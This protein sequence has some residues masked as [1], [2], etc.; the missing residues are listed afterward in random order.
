MTNRLLTDEI[1]YCSDIRSQNDQN[2]RIIGDFTKMV[3]LVPIVEKMHALLATDADWRV[4][5]TEILRNSGL[6]F[7]N[8]FGT[9]IS[10]LERACQWQATAS[11]T[12]RRQSLQCRFFETG[13]QFYL[14]KFLLLLQLAEWKQK[15]LTLS[16]FIKE[17]NSPGNTK[18]GSAR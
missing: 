3:R 14:G 8:R 16:L 15:P 9:V 2:T 12:F 10:K 5:F 6:D 1:N 18:I 17:W 4:H 13:D 7:R 11:K